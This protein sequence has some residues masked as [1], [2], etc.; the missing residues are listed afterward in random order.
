MKNA[1]YADTNK[2]STS[3][4]STKKINHAERLALLGIMGI[5]LRPPL[6][7]LEHYCDTVSRDFN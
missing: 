5:Q 2:K 3:F 6:K 4:K 7:L 1:Q